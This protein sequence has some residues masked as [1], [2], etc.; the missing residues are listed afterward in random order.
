MADLLH[1]LDDFVKWT[2]ILDFLEKY[3]SG[4][5]NHH[6]FVAGHQISLHIY[7]RHCPLRL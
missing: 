5:R 2:V 6:F 4:C 1:L 7:C 3:G